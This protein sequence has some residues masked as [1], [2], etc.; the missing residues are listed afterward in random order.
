MR[1]YLTALMSS[2]LIRALDIDNVWHLLNY[3]VLILCSPGQVFFC[4]ISDALLY[5]QPHTV[6]SLYMFQIF[7]LPTS[8]LFLTP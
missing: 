5:S 1:G 8:I 2:I 6:F 3:E 4:L 7:V